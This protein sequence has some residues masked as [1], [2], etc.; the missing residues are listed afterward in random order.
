M[1]N[2]ELQHAAAV[3]ITFLTCFFVM[4]KIESLKMALQ[5]TGFFVGVLFFVFCVACFVQWLFPC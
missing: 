2:C 1:N 3:G 5:V 4:W